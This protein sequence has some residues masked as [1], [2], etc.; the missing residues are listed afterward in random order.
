MEVLSVNVGRATAVQ[1]RRAT[2][3]TGIFKR[4]VHDFPVWV[5]RDGLAG[6]TICSHQ[7]HGGP[8]QAVYVYGQP[9]YEWWSRELGREL[10]P[11]MFGENL[12]VSE[13]ES[14][15]CHV[16]DRF[17][18]G[19]LVLEATA[20]RIPCGTFSARMEDPQFVQRFRAAERPGVYCRVLNEGMAEAG[21][22]V[23]FEACNRET[24]SIIEVFRDF[25]EPELSEDAIRRFLAAPIAARVRSYK[26]SQL[27][28]LTR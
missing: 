4:S 28:K 24:V 1:V 23:R 5:A 21:A 10:T 18:I 7:H 26:E 16:G 6:D 14:A 17:E 9:D 19:A 20:P 15:A 12:T 2:V 25:Y 3:Q 27:R 8:D 11:G 22:K 13:F